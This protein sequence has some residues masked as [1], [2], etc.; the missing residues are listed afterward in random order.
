M[1]WFNMEAIPKSD[2]KSDIR[3]DNRFDFK[4]KQTTWIG[5][6]GMTRSWS[7]G[8]DDVLK[9]TY[10][11]STAKFIKCLNKDCNYVCHTTLRIELIC[12]KNMEA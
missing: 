6:V 12:Q 5:H 7:H 9:L 8:H 4:I 3:F 1:V 10:I 2:I 11:L